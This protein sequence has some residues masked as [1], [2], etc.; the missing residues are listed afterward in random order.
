MAWQCV[1]K[2]TG[3]SEEQGEKTHLMHLENAGTCAEMQAPAGIPSW[4][5]RSYDMNK[6][7]LRL[8]WQKIKKVKKV[9]LSPS[10]LPTFPLHTHSYLAQNIVTL[11]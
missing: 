8:Y 10:H 2:G 7:I 4:F 11:S 9:N 1:M 5:E 3:E 6:V